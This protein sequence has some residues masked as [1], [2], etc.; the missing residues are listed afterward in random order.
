MYARGLRLNRGL[1]AK[2][3]LGKLSSRTGSRLGSGW[4]ITHGVVGQVIQLRGQQAT[5]DHLLGDDEAEDVPRG[6]RSVVFVA[7]TFK[8]FEEMPQCGV[9]VPAKGD[10]LQVVLVPV[11]L[12][13]IG[14]VLSHA[15]HGDG[16]QEVV[17]AFA[18]PRVADGS[19]CEAFSLA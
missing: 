13:T 10:A 9:E 8:I 1:L 12:R 16:M 5:A 19:G 18:L 3:I 7:A 11:L 15:G 17:P 14:V 2:V 4:V 6:S